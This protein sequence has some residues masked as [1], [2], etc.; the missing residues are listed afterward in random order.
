MNNKLLEAFNI[1]Q[2]TTYHKISDY[3]TFKDKELLD[4]F[5]IEILQ[6]LSDKGHTNINEEIINNEIEKVTIGYDLNN[7]ERMYLI[8][9]I[10]GEINGNGPLTELMKDN[11]ITEIMVNSPEDI[12]IEVDGNIIKDES[13]SFIN[14]EH[15]LRTIEKL[16]EPSNKTIDYNNPIIDTNLK[17]GSRL[18]AIIPPL[19]KNPIITIRKFKQEMDDIDTLIGNGTLTPY[20]ARFLKACVEARLN[21]IISGY[22][23]SGKTT[24][25]NILSNFIPDNE[26]I[27]TIEDV[28]ELKLNNKHVISLETTS[29]DLKEITKKDLVKNSIKMRPDRLVIGEINGNEVMSVLQ[30]MN[31]GNEGSLA[32]VYA[33]S[34]RDA[35]NKLQSLIF[36]EG[37]E[38]SLD[39]IKTYIANSIDIVVHIQK[40]RDG[41]KKITNISEINGITNGEINIKDIFA[42]TKQTITENGNLSGEFILYNQIPKCLSKIKNA[43]INDI[44]DMFKK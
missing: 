29:N 2:R 36:I 15:I 30:A 43:G 35:I 27:I 33:N 8:N 22:G 16:I 32:T 5:R 11:N 13:V 37:K 25:L 9:L 26:R 39:A 19:S 12:Y 4:K 23:N 24:L 21:I 41:K 31:T 44:D 40:M 3:N 18:N 14:N 34:S 1:K 38:L 17:D 6:E 20:M 7:N 28:Y 42:F 10:D